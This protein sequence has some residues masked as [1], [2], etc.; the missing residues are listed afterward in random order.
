MKQYYK[1]IIKS[2]LLWQ[3]FQA[4]KLN[5]F[6]RKWMKENKATQLLPMNVFDTSIVKAGDYSY[7]ELNVVSFGNNSTLTIGDYVSIA[8]NVYFLLDVEHHINHI[9]TY[10][11]R[12]KMLQEC[13]SESFAKGNT[14]VE[15]DAWIGFGAIVMSGVTIGKGAIVAAGAVV[16]KDVPP[17]A[18]VAGVPAKVIRYRF[19]DIVQNE[20]AKMDYSLLTKEK[21]EKNKE[22]LYSPVTED[23]AREYVEVLMQ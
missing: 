22:L 7:G 6:R 8:E 4:I 23:N 9:S 21:V 16:T 10:P 15:D 17:Y 5:A 14:V 18:I 19:P 1:N 3:L 12:V 2:T 13:K 11:F 20:V